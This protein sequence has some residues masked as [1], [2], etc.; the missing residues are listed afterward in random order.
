MGFITAPREDA[1]PGALRKEHS[2]W[3]P[4]LGGGEQIHSVHRLTRCTIVF[5]NRRLLIVDEGPTGRSF[6]Y[7][8]YPYRQIS[9]FAVEAAGH[10]AAEAD[11]RIWVSGRSAPV[12][13]AFG[14]GVDVYEV[15]ALL[16]QHVATS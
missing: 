1:G 11:L 15:Q 7:A 4:L 8:S 9:H 3:A 12:E 14:A 6:E 13:K 5:T 10:F 16:A 2:A